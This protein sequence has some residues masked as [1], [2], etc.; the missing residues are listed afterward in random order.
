MLNVWSGRRRMETWWT[1]VLESWWTGWV[2][3][4]IIVLITELG[5]GW[6]QLCGLQS[7][8]TQHSWAALEHQHH[9]QSYQ[10][11]S[12][13]RKRRVSLETDLIWPKPVCYYYYFGAFNPT[14]S[15][16]YLLF[17]HCKHFLRCDFVPRIIVMWTDVGIMQYGGMG[18]GPEKWFYP[19]CHKPW[20]FPR[21][22]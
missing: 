3:F 5:M 21:N 1:M 8:Y 6:V 18:M 16:L 13:D 10:S 11:F 22:I 19:N 4:T 14:F 7:T 17:L 12:A 9:H 2:L 15:F 20:L